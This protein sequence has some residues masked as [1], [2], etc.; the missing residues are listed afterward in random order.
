MGMSQC[1][2]LLSKSLAEGT[3]LDQPGGLNTTALEAGVGNVLGEL[4]SH[5]FAHRPSHQRETLIWTP[6]FDEFS[7][8]PLSLSLSRPRV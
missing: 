4:R 8:P 2:L 1:V 3:A 7:P 6:P 5:S